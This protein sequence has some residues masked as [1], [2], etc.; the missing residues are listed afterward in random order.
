MSSDL[1]SLRAEIIHSLEH[2]LDAVLPWFVSQMPAAYFAD[3]PDQER[4]A[5]LRALLAARASAMPPRITLHSEDRAR[6]TFLMDGDRPGMLKEILDQLPAEAPLRQVKVHT[7][8]DGQLAIDT[9]V[10]GDVPRYD[11]A[12]PAQQARLDAIL[13]LVEKVRGDVARVRSFLLSSS[14]DF[15]RSATALR[16]VRCADRYEAVR[17]TEDTLVQLEPEADPTLSRIVITVGNATPRRMFERCADLI[18]SHGVNIHRAFVD[19]VEDPGHG[20]VTLFSYLVRGPDGRAL[21]ADGLVWRA[22]APSLARGKWITD[23]ALSLSHNNPALGLERAEVVVALASLAHQRL[24][25]DNP[26][27]FARDRV[28]A[29]AVRHLALSSAIADLLHDRFNPVSAMSDETYALRSAALRD[30]IEHDVD[31]DDARRVLKTLLDAVSATLRTNLHLEK[32]YGLALRLEGGFIPRGEEKPFGVYFVHGQGWDGFHLRFRDIA[33]GGV[34]VV[35]PRGTDQLTAETDRLYDEVYGLAQAQQLKNKD[36]PE[37]GAKA[38]IVASQDVPLTRA[39]KGF[40]DGV[41]DLM[42]ADEQHPLVDR[43][44]RQETLYLGPDENI[45]P[46]HIEWIV[47]RARRRGHKLAAAFMSSKPGAGINHKEYGVT[48][49]G[50]AVFLAVALKAV[51]INPHT[52]DFTIKLTGGPDGDV[53]GNMIKILHREYGERAKIVGISDGSGALE[54]PNGIDHEELLRLV[55]ASEPVG[56]FDPA[57]LSPK[58]RLTRVEAPDGVR[59]R[60]TLHN[61]VVADA[62]VPAGGRP[63]TLNSHNWQEHLLPDGTPSSRVIVEGANLFLTPEARKLLGER[64]VLVLKDSSANKCGVICSSFEITAAHLLSE[65][66]FLANKK[67]FVPQVIERLQELARREAELLF[68]ERGHHPGVLLPEL[69]VRLSKEMN[70]AA[71][72]IALYLESVT[73]EEHALGDGLVREHLPPILRTLAEAR[74]DERM[75]VAYWRSIVAKSLAARIVYREGLDWLNPL[76]DAAIGAMAFQWLRAE[77][78]ARALAAAIRGGADYD[79]AMVATMVERAG[80]RLTLEG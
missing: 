63:Q 1:A 49:E 26:V 77:N 33:R 35:R 70:R 24:T 19:V 22:L 13:A 39:I 72:A 58:G 56:A 69:S 46:E 2:T 67:T 38:V 41:L 6:W 9:I 68:R 71:D 52:Q 55:R 17:G 80:A 28:L 53:A 4:L 11:P 21:D 78:A 10:L 32:R 60:N 79:R 34:R 37:G 20:Y 66:E 54:D 73:P 14:A 74:L 18:G 51:G 50:V 8:A 3:T 42:V 59:M 44:G 62:F 43:L 47:D 29:L 15:V 23:A 16:A 48:S 61:R 64:G 25:R 5:H 27:S 65:G 36:I 45:T 75:P 40:I 7:S 31:G 76:P 12:D 30:Q 57:R